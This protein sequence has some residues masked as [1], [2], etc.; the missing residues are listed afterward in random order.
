MKR[1]LLAK[2]NVGPRS[3]II[4]SNPSDGFAK[5]EFKYTCLQPLRKMPSKLTVFKW[6]M[7]LFVSDYVSSLPVALLTNAPRRRL[8]VTGDSAR[9]QGETRTESSDWFFNVTR[10]L[11]LNP[12]R[13]TISNR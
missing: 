13:K 5:C 3:V 2:G 10:D 4:T 12:T 7:F 8:V 9:I 1:D 6:L 11:G